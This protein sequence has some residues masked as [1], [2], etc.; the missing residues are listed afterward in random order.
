[1]ASG[2]KITQ[3]TD[4]SPLQPNDKIPIARNSV[5]RFVKGSDFA[6]AADIAALTNLITTNGT[7][8][9]NTI[10][11][12]SP[13]IASLSSLPKDHILIGNNANVPNKVKVSGDI[14]LTNGSTAF[15]QIQPNA[16]TYAKMQ[17]VTTAN[18]V[19]GS[20]TNGG[21]VTEIEIST[22]MVQDNTVTLQKLQKSTQANVVL[23]AT[24]PGQNFSELKVSNPMLSPVNTGI[25]K[26][27]KTA[28]VGE[29]ED[30]TAADLCTLLGVTAGAAPN[31]P[32]SLIVSQTFADKVHID[33]STQPGTN[34]GVDILSATATRAGVMTAQDRIKFDSMAS[35][36]TSS[37]GTVTN[38]QG[39]LPIVVSAGSTGNALI[40]PLIS[41]NLATSTAPGIITSA[42]F[43][44][45]TGVMAGNSNYVFPGLSGDVWANGAGDTWYQNVVPS[46]KGGAGTL[47]GILSADGTGQVTI[48]AI[49]T[50]FLSPGSLYLTG[51]VKTNGSQVT[52]YDGLVPE[53]LGG[54]GLISGILKANG[55]GLVSQAIANTDYFRPGDI[56]PS[57]LYVLGDVCAFFSSDE[58]LKTNIT[59]ISNALNK[60]ESI[61]GAE[62]KWNEQLQSTHKGNDVGVI[63]Q[64]I[65]KI[66]PTAVTDRENGYKAVKY[67]KIIPLLIEA[68]KELSAEIKELKSKG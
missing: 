2:K 41:V 63:A 24:A 57:N 46:S 18:R 58:R 47:N 49:G 52:T 31:V 59:P 56:Y 28:G 13:I 6:T 36:A 29:V 35:G 16:V 67:E 50:S 5:N 27:R 60:V 55:L 23:G 62:F 30:I 9:T 68:I 15:A 22:N 44:A 25:V 65:E 12:N 4:G 66:L 54:A 64:E 34:T 39:T 37:G 53:T 20:L 45:L 40:T 14:S 61:C 10:W 32:T 21:P 3:L 38:V 8:T 11:A 33:S 48:A 7:N 19:L 17:T 51:A 1:M 43:D 26:G 42:Q